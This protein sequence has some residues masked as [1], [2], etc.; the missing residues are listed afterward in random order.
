MDLKDKVVV[1]T[2][3]AGGLG[4]A[5]AQ[6]F[7]AAGA[8]LALIDVDQEKLERACAELG[9]DT[10]VQGYALDITDEEDVVAG[11]G[12]IMED[13][14][15][16]NVLVN[17]AGILRDGMLVKAKEGKVIDRMSLAQFQSVINVNLTGSFLCGREAAAAMIES[18]QSG[19]IVNISS[20]AKAGNMGQSN[21]AASKAGVAAMTVG[22][23]KEL[24]RYNIRSA[25][26]AP[27]VIATE[28][29]AAMKP[30][31]LERLEKLVPVGRLGQAEEIASTVRFIIE[32]EYVN[33]RVFEIDGGIRL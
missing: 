25:A 2:G 22:W 6:N 16:V 3:G 1:I 30:E 28:M 33:G 5:M 17:N 21:Y 20:L 8:K 4:L 7:A 10:E 24:A 9:A 23:A 27:G 11:F 18:G 31:A 19:V 12:F 29:T 14:G 32:N 13:F 15:Q 26:V